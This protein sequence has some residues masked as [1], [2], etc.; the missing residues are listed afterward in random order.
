MIGAPL[1]ASPAALRQ[2]FDA[3]LVRLIEAGGL[4]PFILVAA[5][6][7]FDARL[8]PALRGP[9]QA[10]Y[11]EL[12]EA[13]QAARQAGQP[14]PGVAEDVEVFEKI[15]AL[16]LTAL[17]PTEF[18]EAGPW[19]LQF[20]PLRAF[21]PRRISG[22]VPAGVAAPFDPE[23]FH[24]NRP[25]LQPECFWSGSLQ[26]RPVDLYYNKYPF[27]GLHGLLVPE[28][29]AE[30]PQRLEAADHDWLWALC[31]ELG[32]TLPG[33]GFGYN[34]YGAYAS[35]NHLHFQ[36]FLAERPLPVED[37][38]WCHNGGGLDYPAACETYATP[39]EAW[40]RL[41]ALHRAQQ[42]C[43]LLYV[44]GRLYLFP[45]RKQGTVE[46]PAWSSGFTWFELAG[47]LVSFE[48]EAYLQLDAARIEAE[49]AALRPARE[50]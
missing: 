26:G 7:T 23:G 35:V 33:I 30:W 12:A 8:L 36:M 44:P 24:F 10:A 27:A 38:R 2:A 34:G 14:L 40:R 42:P 21:R 22:R 5:N 1:F 4:G 45:R 41:E 47:G 43:N 20:N 19:Q 50:V 3:G 18:R 16:G 9:L 17:Q 39:G 28:R 15:H 49:L 48:R 25:F 11:R 31:A 46:V 29:E 6:A 32:E 37:G 13:L